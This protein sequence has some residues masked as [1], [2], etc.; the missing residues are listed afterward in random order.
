MPKILRKTPS[1]FTPC[2]FAASGVMASSNVFIGIQG[3]Q[4]VGQAAGSDYTSRVLA[5]FTGTV[6]RLR[7]ALSLGTGVGETVVVTLRIN[8]APSAL[9]VTVPA[10]TLAGVVVSNDTVAVDVTADDI[11]DLNVNGTGGPA[12]AGSIRGGLT[13]VPALGV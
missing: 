8:G 7:V 6:R 11:L 2:V 9:T 10:S 5:P 3:C 12:G 4:Q 1:G 13:L